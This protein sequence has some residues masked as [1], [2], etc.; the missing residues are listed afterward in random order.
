MILSRKGQLPLM[1]EEQWPWFLNS[2]KS[3]QR[4]VGPSTESVLCLSVASGLEGL[5]W[6][7]GDTVSLSPGY[8]SL[9]L[10]NISGLP[11]PRPFGLDSWSVALFLRRVYFPYLL[12]YTTP[13][14]K[15]DLGP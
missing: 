8:F 3:L 14:S 1:P 13:R 11:A 7:Q 9:V 12:L 6:G 15:K 2:S 10:L 5:A 4:W